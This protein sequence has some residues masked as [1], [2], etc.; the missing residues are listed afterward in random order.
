M[1]RKSDILGDR[2]CFLLSNVLCSISSSEGVLHNGVE[3][4]LVGRADLVKGL[5][6]FRR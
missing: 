5:F 3:R 6:P 1:G 4:P 2:Y